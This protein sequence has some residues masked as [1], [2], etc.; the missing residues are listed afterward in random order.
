MTGSNSQSK[1]AIALAGLCAA[2]ALSSVIYIFLEHRPNGHPKVVYLTL[3]HLTVLPALIFYWHVSKQTG[4]S[5]FRLS[6]A[7]GAAAGILFAIAALWVSASIDHGRVV[8]DE[9]A[10]S[11]QA[12]IFA[13]GKL[14]AE[15]MPGAL[16][17]PAAAP[18]EIYFENTI[19][20]PEGWYAKYPPGWP[21]ILAVGEW[22]RFPWIVNPIF[23]VLQ[24]LVIWRMAG[25]WSSNAG[26]LSVLVA[27]TSPYMV[28]DNAG[29]LSHGSEA[30]FAL[31]ALMFVMDGA[32]RRRLP[33]IVFSFGFVFI[34]ILVRPFTGAV[35]A[36][37]CTSIVILELH[38]Y[39]RILL[40]AL[41]VIALA[42]LASVAA[43][44]IVN[45]V[46]TGHPLLSPYALARGG[47]KVQELIMDPSE[48]VRN[49]LSFWRWSVTGTVLTM[50][51]FILLF[52]AYGCWR[53]NMNRGE[54]FYLASLFPLL[55][56]ANFFYN[57]GHLGASGSFIG[58]RYYYE[59]FCPLAIAA[60]R[61]LD[62]LITRWRI[63]PIPVAAGLAVLLGLQFLM[64]DRGWREVADVIQPYNDAYSLAVGSPPKPL[65]FIGG[66]T[67]YFMSKHVNWNLVAW[68]RAP[69]VF[70]NDPGPTGREAAACL[71]GRP[72]YRVVWWDT[73]QL[74][75]LKV[76][77]R[78]S[79]GQ[80]AAAYH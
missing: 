13:A 56:G 38:R 69:V 63:R 30:L 67:L 44:L 15:A 80:Q 41:A 28:I 45:E 9:T 14:K 24:L 76:D 26:V 54:L 49:I 23:G 47:T 17:N 6:P 64:L 50:W 7:L 77:G 48:I 75:L 62:L 2:A 32:R 61:G 78:A 34:S 66:T 57:Y 71:F 20:T 3:L 58:E 10:Y 29:Y 79:C 33:P 19:Q 60:G 4:D 42:G 35:V 72:D 25:R 46:F 31:L 65:V 52:A 74:R 16:P 27:A 55:I 40:Q 37:L 73:T 5:R 68:R 51:P 70:L 1:S 8:A 43:T 12:R 59:G 53:E 39:R 22:L 11:F 36:L 21:L 18:V